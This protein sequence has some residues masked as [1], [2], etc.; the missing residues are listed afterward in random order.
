MPPDETPEPPETRLH[1]IGHSDHSTE[2]FTDLL[3]HYTVSVLVDVRSQPYSRWTPQFN[4][5]KLARDLTSA[6]IRYVFMG[7]SLGGRPADRT[8]YEADGKRLDYERVALTPAFRAGIDGLLKLA[9]TACVV[10]M[11]SEG[12]HEQCHRN[13]LITPELLRRGARV[14]HILP[15]GGT[16]EAHL[17]PRQLNM[18]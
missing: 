16:V 11:C 17:E 9:A 8:W 3:R 5:E 18:F 15:D 13:A 2:A 10:V 6:G 14:V 7:D 1:T 4:R 12:D